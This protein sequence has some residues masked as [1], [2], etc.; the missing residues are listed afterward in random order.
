M[1]SRS[2]SPSRVKFNVSRNVKDPVLTRHIATAAT[3]NN[4]ESDSSSDEDEEQQE[5]SLDTSVEGAPVSADTFDK[6]LSSYEALMVVGA[7]LAGFALQLLPSVVSEAAAP[8]PRLLST[9][10]LLLAATVALNFFGLVALSLANFYLAQL[11]EKNRAAVIQFRVRTQFYRQAAHLAVVVSVPLFA[12]A[13]AC[14]AGHHWSPLAPVEALALAALLATV[15]AVLV[16]ISAHRSAFLAALRPRRRRHAAA[17]PV[18]PAAAAAAPPPSPLGLAADAK[19]AAEGIK[20]F[21]TK[22]F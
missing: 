3:A 1:S 10:R 6:L 14:W 22:Y 4:N 21:H 20:R 19:K 18:R 15:V 7:L 11:W 16:T 2:A 17:A 12:L 5:A 8:A 13:V 9:A